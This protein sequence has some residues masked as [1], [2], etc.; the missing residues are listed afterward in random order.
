[1]TT[2]KQN[3]LP[4]TSDPALASASGSVS[5]WYL[6][7]P[8]QLTW[9]DKLRLLLGWNLYIGFMLPE[10]KYPAGGT[11]T[12]AVSREKY[13]SRKL[14]WRHGNN[15]QYEAPRVCACC[16]HWEVPDAL[17]CDECGSDL[18]TQNEKLTDHR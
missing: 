17:K 2:E 11:N 4:P 15:W 13:V 16:G 18:V 12:W 5:P 10:Y 14:N 9:W 3:D 6:L 1:M 8:T 7:S